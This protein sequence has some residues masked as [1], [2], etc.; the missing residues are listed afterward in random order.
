M[1]RWE[2][3]LH[4]LLAGLVLLVTQVVYLSTM[5]VTCPFWDSGEFIATSFTL[6]I[7]HPPGTPLYVLIG[8]FFSLLPFFPQVATRVNWLSALAAS[9]T[10]VFTYLLT[11]EFWLR[12]RRGPGLA[13]GRPVGRGSVASGGG[14]GAP[15]GDDGLGA[16]DV[17]LGA[18]RRLSAAL[19][20]HWPGIVGG[21]A[22]AFFTAFS[23]TFWDNAGEAEVY[24]LSSLIMAM[25][26]WLILRWARWTG[27]R[28]GKTG[29]FLVLYYLVC[30]S[31]GI[32]LGT[33]LVLPGIILFALLVD[34]ESFGSTWAEAGLV[35][36]LVLLLHPGL[37]PV[38][39]LWW[40]V[41]A[42]GILVLVVLGSLSLI[43]WKPVGRRGLL[44]WCLLLA[45]IGLSTHF[46]LMIRA[47]ADPS[48]NEAD[49]ETWRS[50]WLVLTRDQYKPA[51]QFVRQAPWSVQLTKHW[52]DYGKDQYAL[53]LKPAWV[54]WLL[55][56]L[57]GFAG[58]WRQA[59]RDGKGFAKLGSTWLITSLLMV[60]YLNFKTEE[61]RPRD[62]F[63]TA[64]YQ[65][66]AVWIGLGASWMVESARGWFAA[67]AGAPPAGA[68]PA[69]AVRADGEG[70]LAVGSA[71]GVSRTGQGPVVA[72]ALGLLLCGLPFLTANRYW[73]EHDRTDFWL[74]RD[75]AWNMLMPLKQ[76]AI[77]FTNGDN[78]TFP[79]WYLQEVEGIR[80]DVRV[81]N[82]SLLNTDWYMRQVRDNSPRI[83]L[84]W[85]DADVAQVARGA[86]Y[87]GK[88]K[89]I[90]YIK[91]QAVAR[92]VRREYGKRPIYVA[93]TVPELMGLEDALVMQ[94]LVF[95]LQEP[96]SGARDRI[97]ADATLKNLRE[98]YKY[99]GLLLPD[100]NPDD[101]VYK[102]ENARRLVQNYAA[103]LVRAAQEKSQ[104]GDYFSAM[105]AMRLGGNIAPA[106]R[107]IQYSLAALKIQMRRPEEA[108]ALL[109]GLAAR[110][111]GDARLFLLLGR[112]LEEQE[113]PADAEAQYRKALALAPDDFDSLSDL[114]YLLWQKLDRGEEGIA[115]LRDW[116]RRHPNN[117]RAARVLEELGVATGMPEGKR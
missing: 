74:A 3:R 14:V 69:T 51:S 26:A 63:F 80:R 42:L 113:K 96:L 36:G 25:A 10:A 32:H 20:A 111:W 72:G 43:S 4:W 92:I 86:Y 46:Y 67:P 61:V 23:R 53:G 22:A 37:L 49:P 82:L 101:S 110:G 28:A 78:D 30:L 99:R 62:Y 114:F 7:P 102:D 12:M 52:L 50:L 21:L 70:G 19:V 33:F 58:V 66:F 9:G 106:S 100:G 40:G 24:A 103:G 15:G 56:Y 18:G 73:Y 76:N 13:A 41:L 64:S 55:P 107:A 59:S 34:R 17:G 98:V 84:G 115:L 94:G 90:V 48:I 60:F 71:A 35:A 39:R 16:E 108:E 109:R 116:A 45:V 1:T 89:R 81:A 29:L 79:L 97:D 88:Q 27:S 5:A 105:E 65:F 87:D 83:D 57:L 44:T 8:R 68:A 2:E 75:F 38:L 91:D 112:S 11:V 93:V 47:H 54:G 117:R 77:L 85:S 31:M 6:G 95:E 104:Q